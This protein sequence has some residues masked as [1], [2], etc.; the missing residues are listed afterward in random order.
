MWELKLRLAGEAAWPLFGGRE[1]TNFAGRALEVRWH[2]EDNAQ[3]ER[4]M[5]ETK[6]VEPKMPTTASKRDLSHSA[7]MRPRDLKVTCSVRKPCTPLT[8]GIEE[9]V[10]SRLCCRSEHQEATQH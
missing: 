2:E 4:A 1:L 7:S 5:K 10:S 8:E 3:K 9:L 6:Q